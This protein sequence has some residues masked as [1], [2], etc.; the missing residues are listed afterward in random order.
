MKTIFQRDMKFKEVYYIKYANLNKLSKLKIIEELYK[1]DNC[2]FSDLDLTEISEKLIKNNTVIR[3]NMLFMMV[4]PSPY[5][6]ILNE[7]DYIDEF[8]PNFD[9]PILDDLIITALDFIQKQPKISK[10]L[11]KF[12]EKHLDI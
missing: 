4:Y 12:I 5:A 7:N 6:D 3:V 8:I 2:D 11:Q 1:N 10:V 9:D